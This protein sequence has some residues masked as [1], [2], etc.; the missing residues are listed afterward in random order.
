MKALLC[1]KFGPPESLVV[2][3]IE[4]PVAGPGEVV[5]DVH[6]AG[7][8]FPDTLII[9]GKYQ[10][11][12]PFPFAPGG[13]AAGTIAEVG[14]GVTEYKVGDRVMALCGNGAFAEKLK[15]EASRLM[16]LPQSMSYA[17]GAGFPMIYGTSWHALKQRAHL[18]AGETLLV[19]GAAGGV[20]YSAV[21]LGKAV[22]ARVIAC[23]SS[24]EKLELAKKAGADEVI[25]YDEVP[26]FKDRVKEL[27]NGQGADVIYDP[28]GGKFFDQCMRCVNWNGRVLVIGFTAGIPQVAMNL[29]LLKGCQIVG[30][31]WGAF[32]AREPE[33]NAEN[34]R[35][36]FEMHRQGKD[37][38]SGN[39]S[40]PSRRG[41]HSHSLA[42][43]NARLK[44]S[45][46]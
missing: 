24:A 9:A 22:G 17:E 45:S 35:E 4:D 39:E 32:T 11:Q 2:E 20:G 37:H 38:T 26:A 3:E 23:A 28:V 27:T 13:E 31:F 29:P 14:E 30:V 1:K 36:L 12:P 21:E 33:A 10:F 8:N 5:I 46:S 16:S 6:C 15:V 44:A 42:R 7:V 34:F 43:L 40:F 41:W 18:Q 25:N 19:L